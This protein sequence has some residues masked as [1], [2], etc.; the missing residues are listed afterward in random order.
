MGAL[1]CHQRGSCLQRFRGLLPGTARLQDLGT[2]E[3]RP[4]EAERGSVLSFPHKVPTLGALGL[5]PG[6][7]SSVC[8]PSG[9]PGSLVPGKPDQQAES[10][11]LWTTHA[12]G[13]LCAA[14][15][16]GT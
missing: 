4:E 12:Q 14:F 9:K 3:A 13:R 6:S 8:T 15:Y 10:K 7:L 2:G 11:Y 16:F 5:L 1:V